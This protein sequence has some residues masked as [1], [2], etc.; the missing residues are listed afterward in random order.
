MAVY[1]PIGRPGQYS[2]EQV[3]QP[4][5][6]VYVWNAITYRWEM[7]GGT[8]YN[9]RAT[10]TPQ[11]VA[12]DLRKQG[13]ST[14]E[15]RQKVA[16]QTN[17]LTA[18]A[19]NYQYNRSVKT[20]LGNTILDAQS[21]ITAETQIL[22]QYKTGALSK[23]AKDSLEKSGELQRMVDYNQ[24][25]AD[26]KVD[27]VVPPTA[28]PTPPQKSIKPPKP[29][30]P[31]PPSVPVPTPTPPPPPAPPVVPDPPD[32]DDD[33]DLGITESGRFKKIDT[34]LPAVTIVNT[35]PVTEDRNKTVR[36]FTS[37][38]RRAY[39]PTTNGVEHSAGKHTNPLNQKS[40]LYN[41]M[42]RVEPGTPLPQPFGNIEPIEGEVIYRNLGDKLT[43]FRFCI[44]FTDSRNK[45][46]SKGLKD[47]LDYAKRNSNPYFTSHLIPTVEL[48]KFKME[49]YIKSFKKEED[50]WGVQIYDSLSS[51]TQ[52]VGEREVVR[53]IDSLL[54]DSP[55]DLTNQFIK[56]FKRGTIISS[57]WFSQNREGIA[58]T[59]DIPTPDIIT[60]N[61]ADMDTA[62]DSATSYGS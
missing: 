34:D 17:R 46:I 45:Y 13:A 50:K 7:S 24:T 6:T 39:K 1:S 11:Q 55:T 23:E 26:T 44:L 19:Q 35:Y 14:Q 10:K 33:A 47:D 30:P 36:E 3:T 2:F 38:V 28:A 43:Q 27:I 40:G 31:P 59:S 60:A 22:Q 4:D 32:D 5:G 37:E 29:T 18:P 20:A 41:G 58:A 49:A 54:Y 16:E 21:Q 15:I 53:Y 48:N 9:I 62:S 12:N 61:Q 8:Q 52:L 42:K 57:H 51:G 25:F 56:P